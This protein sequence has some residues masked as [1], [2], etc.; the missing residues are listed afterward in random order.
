MFFYWLQKLNDIAI[1]QMKSLL[2][3]AGMKKLK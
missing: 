1:S 3:S 2:N